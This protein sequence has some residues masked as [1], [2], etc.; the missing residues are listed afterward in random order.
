[1]FNFFYFPVSIG[2]LIGSALLI[3]V[4]KLPDLKLLIFFNVGILT[5]YILIALYWFRY[6][7][8]S[9]VT[10]LNAL[11]LI[12]SC[13][14]LGFSW[15]VYQAYQHKA[16]ILEPE[17]NTRLVDIVGTVEGLPIQNSHSAQFDL[18]LE[19]IV[20]NI[21]FNNINFKNNPKNNSTIRVFWSHPTQLVQPGDKLECKVLLT[22]IH[23][24]LNPR[25]FDVEKQSLVT[26]L[27]AQ[28]KLKVLTRYNAQSTLSHAPFKSPSQSPFQSQ[29]K[30]EYIPSFAAIRFNLFQN[31]KKNLNNLPFK[32]IMQALVL[33]DK[34]DI[35]PEQWEVLQKTG[36]SHLVAISGLHVSMV[37]GSVFF[38]SSWLYRRLPGAYRRLHYISAPKIGALAA[39]MAAAGYASLAAWSIPTQRAFIMVSI[40]M[41]GIILQRPFPL[42]F[43][44]SMALILV[45]LIMPLAPMSV[46]FWLSFLAVGSLI[47]GVGWREVKPHK[48]NKFKQ[49]FEKWLEPQWVVFVALFPLGILV[50]QQ[51]TIIGP[52]ANLIAI[53]IT[54]LLIVPLDLLGAFFLMILPAHMS[55]MANVFLHT[56]HW[57]WSVL[58]GI[59]KALSNLS[60]SV[61]EQGYYTTGS[62]ILAI[63]GC[64]LLLMPKGLAGRYCGMIAFLPLFLIPPPIPAKQA[65]Y[66]SLLEVGQGLSAVIQTHNHVLVYDTGP[67]FGSQSDAGNRVIVPFLKSRGIKA[68]DMIVLSHSDLDHRGGLA[69]L[70]KSYRPKL[71]L[72]SV[73]ETVPEGVS[74]ACYAGQHWAWD[75]VEFEILS[76]EAQT[77]T[78]HRFDKISEKISDKDSDKNQYFYLN[79][80]NTK[81]LKTNNLSCVLKVTT[82]KNSILLTGD[83]ESMVEQKLVTRLGE[84]LRSTILVVPH[85]GSKSSSSL[86]FIEQV[87]PEY[88]LFSTG[89]YNQWGFPK[90]E[91][92]K[93]YQM[94]GIKTY[95]N[96]LTGMIEFRFNHQT[97]ELKPVCYRLS[98]PKF[99]Q[100]SN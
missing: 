26:K 9:L 48:K 72:S 34:H 19:N 70:M 17:Y 7:S 27:H 11:M 96:A 1:M 94:Q 60:F 90:P 52:I 79:T 41:L 74:Q 25:S 75:G 33:G 78:E 57:V 6:L 31:L 55:N 56:A 98:N 2:L 43:L 64:V 18:R 16:W 82:G 100:L 40:A 85:H 5:L 24:L 36:T 46:G 86:A 63:L 39:I 59:L 93:R 15:A 22:P 38:L 44:Y 13:G 87:A 62:M 10:F 32:G 35:T 71:M 12:I 99:W 83:I 37:A 58:W 42:W 45:L 54:S 81:F 67:R 91:V 69:S 53:P 51:N 20:S 80:K 68:L 23:S 28:A 73:P 77:R 8:V 14:V 3:I 61:I 66:F 84:R 47:F 76:P 88:A 4:N 97:Q 95:N 50:F 89:L 29:S 49:W 92:V 21:N 30:F 65:L